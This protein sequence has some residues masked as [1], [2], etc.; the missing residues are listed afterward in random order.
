MFRIGYTGTHGTG[1]TTAAYDLA[2]ALKKE[3]YDVNIITE[4]ARSH[5][6]HLPINEKA[7]VEAQEWIFAEMLKRELE[8]N[9]EI[10]VC[11]RTLLDVFA[12]TYRIDNNIGMSM[13]PFIKEYMKTYDLVFYMQPRSGYLRKDGTR[14]INK[15]FQKEIKNIIDNI[16]VAIDMKLSYAETNGQRLYETLKMIKE[17]ETKMP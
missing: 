16:L 9:A 11:D 4:A 3:G 12:Y 6:K 13:L 14:S 8:T 17:H 5:P 2:T 10:A 7:T 15:A 1:K